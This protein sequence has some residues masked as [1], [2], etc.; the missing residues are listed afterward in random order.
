MVI[1]ED[2]GVTSSCCCQLATGCSAAVESICT[3]MQFEVVSQLFKV[4]FLLPLRLHTP[5]GA[6]RRG[7]TT[8]EVERMT[9]KFATV[10][11]RVNDQRMR[12]RIWL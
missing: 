1:V 7:G 6:E 8:S 12:P 9:T 5:Y 2:T 10:V 4:V 11:P 3:C